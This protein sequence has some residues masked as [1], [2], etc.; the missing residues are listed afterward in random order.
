MRR[1]DAADP[2]TIAIDHVEHTGRDTRLMHD[3]SKEDAGHRGDLGWLQH[4]STAGRQC[5]A[6][7]QHHLIHR[8][9]PW[10][11]QGRNPGSLMH[12]VLSLDSGAVG[13]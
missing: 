5:R 8:P 4:H 13:T 10:C 11:D 2:D 7:Y 6:D 3:F 1:Q 12:D 9:V